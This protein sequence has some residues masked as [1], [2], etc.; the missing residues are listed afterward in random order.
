MASM[1]MAQAVLEHAHRFYEVGGWYVVAE[2]WDVPAVLEELDRHEERSL[3]T[4]ELDAAAIA[5][6][7]ALIAAPRRSR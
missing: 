4:F 3:T 1:A 5:H 6:F 2:C 7:A